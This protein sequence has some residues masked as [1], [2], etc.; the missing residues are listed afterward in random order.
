MWPPTAIPN[1]T[2]RFTWPPEILAAINTADAKV[3]ALVMA[4]TTRLDGS[5]EAS[6]INFLDH[7][8]KSK[9]S[10]TRKTMIIIIIIIYNV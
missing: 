4:I 8:T 9:N 2:A 5:D 1:V 3:N 6:G 7:D 10:L